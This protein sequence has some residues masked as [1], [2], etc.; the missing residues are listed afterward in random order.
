MEDA[1]KA[2]SLIKYEVERIMEKEVYFYVEKLSDL[3]ID[4]I[5]N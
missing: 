2:E 4:P 5:K 1:K 3:I